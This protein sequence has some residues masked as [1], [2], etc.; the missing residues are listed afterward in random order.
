MFVA[1]KSRIFMA[2]TV[3]SFYAIYP[4]WE[5]RPTSKSGLKRYRCLH[6][7]AHPTT[8]QKLPW[9]ASRSP[10]THAYE[11]HILLSLVNSTVTDVSIKEGIGY[12]AV[13]GIIERHVS[14]EVDWSEFEDLEIIGVDEIALKRV[15]GILSR[16]FRS[17]FGMEKSRSW[18]AGRS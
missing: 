2:K 4:F 14:P 5:N 1:K 10:Q 6:C 8:T 16:S 7:K 9:D 3:K 13:M 15:I 17:I 11:N 12:E 18:G